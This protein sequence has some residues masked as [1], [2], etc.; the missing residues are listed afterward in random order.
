MN[1]SLAIFLIATCCV[2]AGAVSR[3]IVIPAVS[4]QSSANTTIRF[5]PETGSTTSSAKDLLKIESINQ[6]KSMWGFQ[7]LMCAESATTS[8]TSGGWVATCKRT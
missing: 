7:S 1:R 3:Q 8:K 2:A 4:N 5:V 6:V